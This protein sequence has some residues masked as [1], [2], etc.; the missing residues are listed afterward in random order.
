MG[1]NQS[2]EVQT[3]EESTNKLPVWVPIILN[4]LMEYRHL[5][6]DPPPPNWVTSLMDDPKYL[7]VYLEK[8]VR[9]GFQ[10]KLKFRS[11]NTEILKTAAVIFTYSIYKCATNFI[12]KKKR[13]FASNT[14]LAKI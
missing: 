4:R 14:F 2:T 3:L 9:N 8:N 7:L 5:L 6:A 11:M 10:E 12:W 13:H 1:C